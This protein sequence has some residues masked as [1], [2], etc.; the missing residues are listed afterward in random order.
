MY[1]YNYSVVSFPYLFYVSDMTQFEYLVSNGCLQFVTFVIFSY[2]DHIHYLHC[3]T[4]CLLRLPSFLSV[5]EG[6]SKTLSR[7]LTFCRMVSFGTVASLFQS[8]LCDIPIVFCWI[9]PPWHVNSYLKLI[10]L[11]D[12]VYVNIKLVTFFFVSPPLCTP[13]GVTYKISL[14][15]LFIRL[16][17]CVSL[18]VHPLTVTSFI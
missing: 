7:Q 15:H 6:P 14:T 3:R 8:W 4:I 2:L 18:V 5:T 16:H 10:Y 17:L 12:I 9:I 1:Q 11:A 13:A